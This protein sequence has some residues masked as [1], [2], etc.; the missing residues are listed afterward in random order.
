MSMMHR[1]KMVMAELVAMSIIKTQANAAGVTNASRLPDP[2]V[3]YLNS[4]PN[5]VAICAKHY[6]CIDSGKDLALD[7]AFGA[8]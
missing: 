6:H 1:M 3:A 4:W 5:R 2:P 8:V 7:Q